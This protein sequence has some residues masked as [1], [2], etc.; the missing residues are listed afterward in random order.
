MSSHLE[1]LEPPP[2]PRYPPS[3]ESSEGPQ[4]LS[5]P[6]EFQL[7]ADEHIFPNNVQY[8]QVVPSALLTETQS[9]PEKWTR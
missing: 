1:H 3:P 6:R 5:V 9:D 7:V 2:P 8:L 4:D